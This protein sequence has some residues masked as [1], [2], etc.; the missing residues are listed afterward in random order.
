MDLDQGCEKSRL[1]TE[2]C[3]SS[4]K[5]NSSHEMKS[6]SNEALHEK[7]QNL[8]RKER[9]LLV[10]IMVYLQEVDRRRLWPKWLIQ[11]S[12]IIA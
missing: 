2:V 7:V 11:A 6:L 10:D 3:L 5:N 9:E 4:E 1:V 8:V 12:T